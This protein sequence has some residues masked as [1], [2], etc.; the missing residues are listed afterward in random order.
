LITHEKKCHVCLE[1]L[2]LDSRLL[3]NQDDEN[4]QPFLIDTVIVQCSK[5]HKNTLGVCHDN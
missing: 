2:T 1:E 5:G 3:P 4:G